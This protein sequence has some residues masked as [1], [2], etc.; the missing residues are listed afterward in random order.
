MALES[1]TTTAAI[2][3]IP[4][5]AIIICASFAIVFSSYL[6][7]SKDEFGAPDLIKSHI[8]SIVVFPLCS[9]ILCIIICKEF[10]ITK[11]IYTDQKNFSLWGQEVAIHL[12]FITYFFLLMAYWALL[13]HEKYG[14]SASKIH[15]GNLEDEKPID[16]FN[17]TGKLNPKPP[18]IPN[19]QKA[20]QSQENNNLNEPSPDNSQSE[21]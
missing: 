17:S 4:L 7:N 19:Q 14:N 18:Q 8:N 12:L 11:F 3:T 5:H 2:Y 10:F 15:A 20:P 13:Y 21:S 16:N 9:A 6:K 1:T